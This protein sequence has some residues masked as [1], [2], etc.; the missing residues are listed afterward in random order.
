MVEARLDDG[1]RLLALNE[2]FIGHATHQSARYRILWQGHDERQSSS[3]VI[4]TTGT[5]AT[6]WARSIRRQRRT[7]VALPDPTDPRVIENEP[8]PLSYF[9]ELL[10]KHGRNAVAHTRFA[11]QWNLTRAIL[12]A[13]FEETRAHDVP[14][15]LV[16]IPAARPSLS[17][18]PE[19]PETILAGW[20]AT[21]L[22]SSSISL[23]SSC[24]ATTTRSASNQFSSLLPS[25]RP[26][27][28]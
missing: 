20:A 15:L 7:E 21:T 27:F 25:A 1:Q 28:S 16:Y 9:W 8:V 17:P 4:V 14:L 19:G 6:G 2:I 12:D 5:G 11:P 26:F 24:L 10:R 3:G 23:C 13:T 22:F 18:V